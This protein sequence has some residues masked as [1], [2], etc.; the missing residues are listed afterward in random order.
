[1]VFV[2][3]NAVEIVDTW[4]VGGLRGTGSHDY[5][6]TDHFVPDMHTVLGQGEVSTCTGPLYKIPAYTVFPMIFGAVA[7]GIARAALDRV[8]ALATSKVPRA[9][10]SVLRDDPIAQ[11]TL[12]RAEARLRAAR[13]FLREAVET[14]WQV[15]EAG[16]TITMEHRLLARL[17]SAEA[18][19]AAKFAVDTAYD[20]GGGSSVYAK[21]GLERCFRDLHTAT[22]HLQAQPAYYRFCG[23][24]LLGLE[25]GISR[26]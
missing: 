17:A 22:Q 5:R 3:R 25:P 24:V 9:L 23:Q 14:V 8:T 18:I 19:D 21:S 1:M 7:F 16:E 6:M 11:A 15:A 2:P 20:L 10:T 26:F 13:A 4:N 12:G